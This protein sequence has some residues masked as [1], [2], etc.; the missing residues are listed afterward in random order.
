MQ[1]FSL[2]RLPEEI[3]KIQ[4][5]LDVIEQI[6]LGKVIGQHESDVRMTVKEAADF[7]NLTV[8]TI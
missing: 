6:L 8:P 4:D 5:K 2:E 7:L 1:P 3:K